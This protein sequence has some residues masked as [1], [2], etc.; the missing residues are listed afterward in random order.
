MAKQ[1]QKIQTQEVDPIELAYGQIK[2]V[3]TDKWFNKLDA[4]QKAYYKAI[5]TKPCVLVDEE[6]GTGKTFVA[7]LNGINH[8][9][10]GKVNK[11]M[12]V[13]LPDKR[14]LKQGF[15]PGGD[16]EKNAPYMYPFYDAALK[17]GLTPEAIDILREFG[18]FELTTDLGMRGRNLEKVFLIIDEAQNG[19]ISDFQL[20]LTRSH[21]DGP[22]VVIGHSGQLDNPVIKIGDLI[23]FQ[24]LQKHM[25]KRPAYAVMCELQNNYRSP[26]VKWV[27][28]IQET[29]NELKSA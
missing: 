9:K 25:L 8:L 12:Y 14:N 5:S 22:V 29:V 28:K 23:P 27:D 4:F 13:R 20:I 11:L 3:D 21:Y 17:C 2:A 1:R 10:E 18:V 16:K 7:V 6:A 15:L 24:V 26:I 19:E